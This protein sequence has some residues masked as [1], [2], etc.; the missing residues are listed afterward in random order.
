MSDAIWAR[1][2]AG[3]VSSSWAS[4]DREVMPGKDAK[5]NLHRPSVDTH[6]R[7][8]IGRH[9]AQIYD[10]VAREPLPETMAAA[11]ESLKN[12]GTSAASQI[13]GD[14]AQLDATGTEPRNPSKPSA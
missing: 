3:F 14:A 5:S 9:L 12:G 2:G 8:A 7:A 10:S 1:G 4:Q 13:D 6:A 11:L